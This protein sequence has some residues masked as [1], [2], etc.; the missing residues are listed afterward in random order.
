[1]RILY[2]EDNPFDADLTRRELRHLSPNIQLD[3][4]DTLAGA[5]E[6]LSVDPLRYAAVLLDLRLPDGDGLTLLNHIRQK[7]LALV[8]IVLTGG[9]DEETVVS[10]LK[11]GAD[12][13]VIKHA[14]YLAGLPTALNDAVLRF[15]AGLHVR[16]R[17]LRVL[18]AERHPQDIDQTRR[19]LARHASY[20]QLEVVSSDAYWRS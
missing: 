2:V 3:V 7:E 10:A 6:Q 19:H 5:F 13:Y 17:R 20:I 8:V 11:A 14:N 12:D 18:Y 16:N 1:M 9:G 15:K 4:V